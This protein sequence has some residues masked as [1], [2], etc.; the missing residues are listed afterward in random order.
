MTLRG[1]LA[2]DAATVSL[3]GLFLRS[4]GADCHAMHSLLGPGISVAACI[5]KHGGVHPVPS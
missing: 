5:E 3:F 1:K 4:S 2:T